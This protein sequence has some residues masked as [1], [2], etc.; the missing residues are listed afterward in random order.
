MK[1]RIP[2]HRTI[3]LVLQKLA[4]RHLLKASSAIA[5]LHKIELFRSL[6]SLSASRRAVNASTHKLE[7]QFSASS[8]P[9]IHRYY[10]RKQH[11]FRGFCAFLCPCFHLNVGNSRWDDDGSGED[12]ALDGALMPPSG[13]ESEESAA[14]TV[15]EQLGYGGEYDECVDEKA[16]R[17]IARFYEEMRKQRRESVG[18]QNCQ[19][20]ALEF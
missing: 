19:V 2:H 14:V 6:V 16:E 20:A 4:L 17:F 10:Y 1:P 3:S 9:L 12:C 15:V 18:S 11:G 13:E 5:K 8:T 7:Y